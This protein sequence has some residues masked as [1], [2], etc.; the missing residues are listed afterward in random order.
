MLF[1]L[2]LGLVLVA[3][4]QIRVLAI[5]RSLPYPQH[6]DEIFIADRA[7]NILR[8]GDFNTH[9]FIYPSLPTYVAAAAMTYGFFDAANHLELKSTQE[10]GPVTYP[11]VLHPRIVRPAR[12]LFA[13]ISVIGLGIVAAIARQLGGGGTAGLAA[14]V[15]APAW[16]G[17]SWLYFELS[18]TYLNVNVIA[19]VMAWALLWLVT[20]RLEQED[21]RIK[22]IYPGILAGLA[23]GCKY[24]YGPIVLAPLLAIFWHGGERRFPKA[25]ALAATTGAVFLLSSPFTLLDFQGFLDGIGKVVYMYNTRFFDRPESQTFFSHLWLNLQEIQADLGAG[26]TFFVLAGA[27]WVFRRDRRRAAILAIF[28]LVLLL[29]MSNLRTHFLR[30]L[31]PL[32]PLWTLL[33]ALG[34]VATARLL[35]ALA[36]RRPLLARLGPPQLAGL[37]LAALLAVAVLFLP[38]G[39]PRKWLEMPVRSRQEA[40]AW[41]LDGRLEEGGRRREVIV[42]EELSLHP[43]P[44]EEA[45]VELR[46]IKMRSLSTAA[47]LAELEKSPDAL[48]LMPRFVSAH[49][50]HPAAAQGEKLLPGLAAL[51]AELEPIKEFGSQMVSVCFDSPLHGDPSFVI[52]RHRRAA[53]VAAIDAPAMLP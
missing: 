13:L 23:I 26:G 5:D 40:T 38:L 46:K 19:C 17:L 25:L 1:F 9:Y 35:A 31:L 51:H 28:P 50:D 18:A 3:A 10:I 45:G 33:G 49:W 24:N 21:W 22:A 44:F 8:T 39:A 48:V 30:N 27:V 32:L 14:M 6:V 37:A 16:L 41:L 15:L 47:F 2:A 29:Q 7:A 36:A 20:S 34:L 52:G 12:L 43:G 4:W 53:P 11:Y 42:A